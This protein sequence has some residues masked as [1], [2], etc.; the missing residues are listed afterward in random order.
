M[1]LSIRAAFAMPLDAAAADFRYFSMPILSL[2]A[3]CRHDTPRR[4]A[5]AAAADEIADITRHAM[6]RRAAYFSCFDFSSPPFHLPRHAYASLMLPRCCCLL[7]LRQR[8]HIIRYD[9]MPRH[10]AAALIDAAMPRR[11]P[12]ILMMPPIQAP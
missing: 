10:A 9:A 3:A 5:A 12:M 11:L 1:L 4:F 2:P 6:L 8:G 7:M